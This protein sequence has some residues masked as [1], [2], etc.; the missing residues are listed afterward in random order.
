MTTPNRRDYRLIAGVFKTQL[1]QG[2]VPLTHVVIMAEAMAEA[3]AAAYV[4]FNRSA[5]MQF[6]FKQ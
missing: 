4:N 6:I 2:G 5:F 1:E 3:L